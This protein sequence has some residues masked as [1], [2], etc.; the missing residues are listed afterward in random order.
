M[1]STSLQNVST[2]SNSSATSFTTVETTTV[3]NNLTTILTN[4]VNGNDSNIFDG[5]ANENSTLQQSVLPEDDDGSHKNPELKYFSTVIIIFMGLTILIVPV[6]CFIGVVCARANIF[7]T[8]R[9]AAGRGWGF[10]DLNVPYAGKIQI[11]MLF[12]F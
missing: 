11:Y 2:A 3:L 7:K 8:L 10:G 5:F 4:F 6:F 12:I 1:E 9:E